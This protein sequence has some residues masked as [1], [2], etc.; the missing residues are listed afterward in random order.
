MLTVVGANKCVNW[1]SFKKWK[2]KGV[3][4]SRWASGLK[5]E[6]LSSLLA[7]PLSRTAV[8]VGCFPPGTPPFLPNPAQG[9]QSC[10]LYHPGPL[11][12]WRPTGLGL[13]MMGGEQIEWT[14]PIPALAFCLTIRCFSLNPACNPLSGPLLSSRHLNHLGWLPLSA[15]L[16]I[17]MITSFSKLEMDFEQWD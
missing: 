13:G 5:V 14:L 4:N 2:P 7:L 3:L 17:Q 10:R 16:L 15:R 12:P 8:T 1:M 11:A 9:S 6:T